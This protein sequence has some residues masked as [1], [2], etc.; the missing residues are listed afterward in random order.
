M[1]RVD[2]ECRRRRTNSFQYNRNPIEDLNKVNYDDDY[3]DD[4][5]DDDDNGMD[6]VI[7]AIVIVCFEYLLPVIGDLNR[8]NRMACYHYRYNT[9]M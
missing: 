9:S 2:G 5:D 1:I 3:D 4:G 7:V 6:C 8:L